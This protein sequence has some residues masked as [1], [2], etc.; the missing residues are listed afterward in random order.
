MVDRTA[1]ALSVFN[2]TAAFLWLSLWDGPRSIGSLTAELLQV[3]PSAPAELAA[4]VAGM[5]ADWRDRGWLQSGPDGLRIL[6]SAADS[7]GGGVAPPAPLLD[8]C[9]IEG[10]RPVWAIDRD[11]LGTSVRIEMAVAQAPLRADFSTRI[12]ALLAGLPAGAGPVRTRIACHVSDGAIHLACDGRRFATRDGAVAVGRLILWCLYAAYGEDDF[13]ASLHAAAVGRPDGMVLLPA[14]SGAG[15]STLAAYLVSQ[16]WAYGGDDVV[17]L[18]RGAGASDV[19]VLPFPTAISVKEGSLGLLE[20]FF[21][22]LRDRA[23]IRYDAKRARFQP[24]DPARIVGRSADL[25]RP[26]A[27][28]FPRFVPEAAVDLTPLSTEEALSAISADGI[29]LGDGLQRPDLHR[30]FS[31]MERIPKYALRYSSLVEAAACLRA[32]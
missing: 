7:D 17:G 3:F 10:C 18:G 15:K 27:L 4:D 23:E 9:S 20:R 14:A 32:L 25:R 12:Q 8:P 26:L 31:F 16:G 24:V 29:G 13:I 28:V 6:R 19:V 21:P 1:G 11:L 22:G 30:L 5:I 2:P